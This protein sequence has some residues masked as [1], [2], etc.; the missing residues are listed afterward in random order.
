M[1][2]LE[3][4]TIAAV[5][6]APEV[7]DGVAEFWA[8]ALSYRI[9]DTER[10]DTPNSDPGQE[11]AAGRSVQL[12]DD[13]GRVRLVVRPREAGG[14]AGRIELRAFDS[15]DVVAAVELFTAA[16]AG[17]LLD[18]SYP[19]EPGEVVMTAPGGTVAIVRSEVEAKP[20]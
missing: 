19:D 2:T 6:V 17:E 7:I 4:E 15:Q 13:T 9:P 16:G 5:D 14:T 8:D 11:Q 18:D 12:V 10:L 20:Q 3:N 1:L